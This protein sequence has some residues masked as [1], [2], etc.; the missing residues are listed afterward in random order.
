MRLRFYTELISSGRLRVLLSLNRKND[1]L[2]F[3]GL[4]EKRLKR[5]KKSG[6]V[7]VK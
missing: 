2:N 1:I 7:V 5:I 3:L 6:V 4:V